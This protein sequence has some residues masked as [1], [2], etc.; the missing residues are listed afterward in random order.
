[1]RE[2]EVPTSSG[3][4]RVWS[5]ITTSRCPVSGCQKKYSHRNK[6]PY[7]KGARPGGGNND[8]IRAVGQRCPTFQQERGQGSSGGGSTWT[9]DPGKLT[10]G[11]GE[12]KMNRNIGGEELKGSREKDSQRKRAEGPQR[13]GCDDREGDKAAGALLRGPFGGGL[14]TK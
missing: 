12:N 6:D 13:K 10:S 8:F 3:K 4:C 1:V 2:R 11:R 9:W 14:L 5:K 7:K